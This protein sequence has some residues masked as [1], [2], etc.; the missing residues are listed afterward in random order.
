MGD[1]ISRL[2]SLS[3]PSLPAW[4]LSVHGVAARRIDGLGL[5]AGLVMHQLPGPALAGKYIGGDQGAAL[6]TFAADHE[7]QSP[8]T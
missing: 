7:P 4:A 3:R 2:S 1:L 5:G 6:E 8:K